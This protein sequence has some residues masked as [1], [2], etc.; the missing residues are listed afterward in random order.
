[1]SK[2]ELMALD[3]TGLEERAAAIAEETR[4]ATEEALEALKAELDVI[5]ERKETI[6]AE[7]EEKRAEMQEVIDGAGKVIEEAQED[8][9][10]SDK[11]IRS[12]KEYLNAWVE[13][14]KAK[15]FGQSAEEELRALYTI[16]ADLGSDE[17]GTIEVPTYVEERIRTAWENDGIMNRVNRTAF[18]GNLKV[19]VEMSASGAVV[20]D[21][22]A[23]AISEEELVI[24][25]V[26]LIPKTLKKLVRFS[27]EVVDAK[28]QE[29]IDY[30]FD[31]VE[32]QLVKLAAA[33]AVAAVTSA[34]TSGTS[35][36]T[37]ASM[38]VAAMAATD[39]VTA[40][41][42]LK[43]DSN[44]LVVIAN[45]ATIAA[46]Q[47]LGMSANYAIDVFAGADVIAFNGLDSFAD[48]SASEAF[49]IVGDLRAIQANFPAG[50]EPRM[51][52]DEITEA[53][54]DM[55]RVIGRLPVAI[56]LAEDGAFT[57]LLKGAESE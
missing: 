7:A 21:E 30:I 40:I 50:F 4:E 26:D 17:T 47:A 52:Y 27:D 3:M 15:A 28:G 23:D 1:M 16:N 6:R 12:T 39:I 38:D 57:V 19:G 46:Y 8:R 24:A 22:G 37:V 18:K 20:H 53:A 54:A 14:Q 44:D 55:V 29:W 11:E 10:M 49:A 45:R 36:P 48:A 9:K 25:Y 56:A 43:T 31:E 42:S 35:A 51:K 33:R 2:E 34:P 13:Y 41:G 5:E 32:Y